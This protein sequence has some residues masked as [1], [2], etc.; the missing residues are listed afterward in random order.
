MNSIKVTDLKKICKSLNIKKYSKMPRETLTENI[1]KF[2]SVLKIQRWTRK[3]LSE[4]QNCPISLEKIFY[5]CFA[6]KANNILIYYKLDTL[7]KYLIESGNFIDPIS[8][9]PYT[10]K[11]LIEMDNIDKY[12]R[13]CKKNDTIFQSVHIFSKKK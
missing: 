5:P 10:D 2:L 9:L 3:I 7:K 8:R 1:D 4:H 11:H 12:F 13:T 6:F